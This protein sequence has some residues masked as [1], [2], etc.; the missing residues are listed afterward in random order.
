MQTGSGFTGPYLT[1][2]IHIRPLVETQLQ[3]Q[4][5]INYISWHRRMISDLIGSGDQ[6]QLVIK[7]HWYF[8][9][10][11]LM[12]KHKHKSPLCIRICTGSDRR[13]WRTEASLTPSYCRWTDP[14]GSHSH[15]GSCTSVWSL[16]TGSGWGILS[17]R[18]WFLPKP[19]YNAADGG[20]GDDPW[21]LKGQF[22]TLVKERII[23]SHMSGF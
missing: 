3:P 21:S 11:V 16:R 22:N 17:C 15:S 6:E 8:M 12:V 4:V 13:R 19:R 7:D 1:E 23:L 5:C 14:R 20:Q 10:T 9:L 2:L 18:S